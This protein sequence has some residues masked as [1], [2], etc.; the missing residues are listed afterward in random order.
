MNPRFV[1]N[2]IDDEGC[3]HVSVLENKKLK[4]G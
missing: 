1:T 4:I 3:F 2:F